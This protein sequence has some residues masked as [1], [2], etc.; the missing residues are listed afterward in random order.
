MAVFLTHYLGFPLGSGLNGVVDQGGRPSARRRRSKGEGEDKKANVN[1][2]VKMHTGRSSMTSRYA[3]LSREELATLVPPGRTSCSF[4]ACA[5]GIP[6]RSPTRSA[7]RSRRGPK[8]L[9]EI[10]A[11]FGRV[12]AARD[13]GDYDIEILAEINNAPR[14]LRR[15]LRAAADA[16]R[17]AGADVIDIGCTPGLPFPR[18]GRR[19]ARA[20]RAPACA[21][22]STAF[23][24]Q[25][26][27][28]AVG[29]GAELVLSVNRSNLGVRAG[30]GRQR[31]PGRRRARAR[32]PA[33]HARAHP[34]GARG[35]A[36]CRT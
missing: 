27:R 11:H 10:P 28:T 24:P 1:A 22:A 34:G 21:S 18:S 33:R 13:Y 35:C 3:A 30:P 26:I 7:C 20:G 19:R 23:D 8:D 6:W 4:P 17:A 14:L 16:F 15:E 25:E 12:A 5:R 9:R 32:R 2:A 29:A 36:A 31:G